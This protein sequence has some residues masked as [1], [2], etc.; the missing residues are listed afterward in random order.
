MS[1]RVLLPRLLI[2]LLTAPFVAL[3]LAALYAATFA[4]SAPPGKIR[5]V[6]WGLP[7][8]EDNKG[9]DAT[10]RAFERRFPHIEVKN[11]SMA[12][13]GM[14][15]QKLMTSI[16]G[17][18]PP[19]LVRQDRFT[20]GDWAARETF[21]PL[22]EF[23]RQDGEPWR[24]RPEEYYPPCWQEAVY[25]G[26]VYAIP[27]STDDR[28]LFWNKAIFREAHLDP[29]KPPRTW[30]ELRQLAVRLTRYRADGTFERIGFIPNWGNSWLYLY[31]WQNG[32]EFMSADGRTCTLANPYTTEAL[33]YMTSVYD[34]LQGAERVS[35]FQS[36][37]QGNELDPFLMG[38]VAMVITVDVYLRNIARYGQDLEF[39]VAP[40]PVPGKRLRGEGRFAGQPQFI[41]WSG[42]FSYAI[43][44]GSRHPRE[45]WL[46]LK[47]MN[48]QAGRRAFHA[49]QRE[50]NEQ[51]GRPYVPDMSANRVVNE[52]IFAEFAPH[53]QD[54]ISQRLRAGMQVGLQMMEHSRFRPVTFVGQRLWDEHVRAFEQSIRHK[55]TPEEALAAGQRVVQKELDKVFS[56]ERHPVLPWTY[57]VAVG[58]LALAA[59]LAAFVLAARRAG[60]VGRLMRGEVR[61]GYLFAG[62]WIVG[63]LCLTAGP[64]LA[65]VFFSFCDYD[66][67]HSPRWVGLTNYAELLGTQPLPTAS[68]GRAASDPIF[69][70]ALGNVAY[71]SLLGIP[72]GMLVSL[73]LA[74]LLN[75]KVRGMHFYRTV[76]YLPSITPILAVAM[77]WPWILNPEYG[78]INA[79]WR[80]T[81]TAAFGLEPPN[82]IQS[83]TWSKPSYILIGL[84][85]AGGG[86]ILWLAGLQG[87]PQHLYEAADLDGATWR[88]RLRYVTL[89]MLTPY[90]FFNLIMGTIGSLQR[91]TDVYV[92]SGPSGGP[93]DSTMVPVLYLFNNAF[94]Y[95]KMGYASALAWVLFLIVLVL[96]VLQ[97]LGGRHWVHYEGERR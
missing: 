1:L 72:L 95:F 73:S 15:A 2:A 12:A 5:L 55:Q 24:I 21:R 22:D 54:A 91:F 28:L 60:R 41:T 67:L 75:T 88:H 11:L 25:R 87:I 64:I 44:R 93:V 78:V 20:I 45:A 35:S 10:I 74:L 97:L 57:P 14:N 65:S 69:W 4:S 62:P 9:L 68:P 89:P 33:A 81:L 42:G 19:D 79:I 34:T 48:S 49:A 61:A 23:I 47:W 85:S 26:R 3:G 53:G 17:S 27:E 29:E 84:W 52:A 77:L 66:V 8:G 63:F 94:Q 38:Q 36:T 37:F 76:Y 18:V 59:A 86:M 46:F 43:P 13:G 40:A 90:I 51:N 96:T 6:V 31:S 58:A 7:S 70:K 39:G 30:T 80:A 83:E 32:G 16:V 50:W 92:I 82:W 71:L 56:R